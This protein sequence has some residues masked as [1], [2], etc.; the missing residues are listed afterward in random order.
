MFNLG[1]F[2]GFCTLP[3]IQRQT[4]V[5]LVPVSAGEQI[6]R[7]LAAWAAEAL[8]ISE[9]RLYYFIFFLMYFCVVRGLDPTLSGSL[10]S[11]YSLSQKWYYCLLPAN[12]S[13]RLPAW[14]SCK[15]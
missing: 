11:I 7:G 9:K 1:T 10:A 8:L 2:V 13:L 6:C 15:C 4:W 12:D 3:P 5:P 14:H